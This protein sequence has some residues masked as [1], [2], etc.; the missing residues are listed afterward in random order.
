MKRML[1]FISNLSIILTALI[2]SQ[3]LW[4]KK[5]DHVVLVH[6][7]FVDASSWNSVMSILLDKGY[8]V[9]AV[10]NPLTSLKDD[11]EAIRRVL[12]RQ[13]ADTI[14]VGYSWAGVPVT[15]VGNHDRV[16]G[17]VYVA[18]M[19]PDKGES[20]H[21]LQQ[22]KAEQATMPGLQSVIDDGYGNY[23]IDP[24][25]YHFALAH[26]ADPAKTRL[27]A[28]SQIPMSIAA[29]DEVVEQVAWKT[30]PSWYAVSSEDKIVS[31][32]LQF[33][34]AERMGAHTISVPSGHAS[35]LSYPDKIAALIDSAARLS[36]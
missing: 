13:T 11:V 34:M 27:M 35:I 26:D 1:F 6:G 4:A 17:L 22:V 19:A 16:K 24:A 15:E 29:F 2:A 25:G 32:Q 23:L 28:A 21:T 8:Q 10:Q 5:I 18:A 36:D 9:T 20:I 3:S 30:K 31:P 33:W 14:L 7:A 12:D